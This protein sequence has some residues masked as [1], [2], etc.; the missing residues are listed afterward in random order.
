MPRG[1]GGGGGG[2][3][4][5]GCCGTRVLRGCIRNTGE[6]MLGSGHRGMATARGMFG[7]GVESLFRTSRR[8]SDRI[9]RVLR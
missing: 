7:G 1:G 6:G 5:S 9:N 8:C 4:K 3:S 2:G